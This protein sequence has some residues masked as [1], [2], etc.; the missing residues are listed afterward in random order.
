MRTFILFCCIALAVAGYAPYYPYGMMVPQPQLA[1]EPLCG[2][3]N[4]AFKTFYN[5]QEFAEATKYNYNIKFFCNGPCPD[6]QKKCTAD[7]PIC[8]SDG[9]TTRTFENTCAMAKEK[10]LTQA[11]WVQISSGPCSND[12]TT[13]TPT[14]T[15]P[16]TT[17]MPSTTTPTTTT[18]TTTA[19]PTTLPPTTLAPTTLPPTTLPPTTLPPTTLPPTTLPPTTLPP[20]TFPPTTLP[21]TTL[22]PTT[23]QPTTLPPT[24]LPPTTLPP[25]STNPFTTQQPEAQ[26]PQVEEQPQVP[27]TTPAPGAVD[28]QAFDDILDPS[29]I[30]Q[31]PT[32]FSSLFELL[33]L[34]RS[35]QQ[36]Q[37]TRVDYRIYNN[38]EFGNYA[39]RDI[40]VGS[41]GPKGEA[42]ESFFAL[43]EQLQQ[44]EGS[45]NTQI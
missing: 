35:Q 45:G 27:A 31:T 7:E 40:Y 12:A 34:L 21:P 26:V 37:P 3:L 32:D 29:T 44:S 24:T 17:T 18:A 28:I 4:G 11:N 9:T 19:P 6:V 10:L 23:V 30:V 16:T 5:F 25:T 41:N 8:A 43:L 36:Q 13:T 42:V 14:T 2:V 1:Y 15:T 33:E 22:P 20:T 39:E 38:N